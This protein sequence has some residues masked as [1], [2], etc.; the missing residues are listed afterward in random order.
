MVSRGLAEVTS[1]GLYRLK[2]IRD[3]GPILSQLSQPAAK[4][5]DRPIPA[6]MKER[7]LEGERMSRE[8]WNVTL[9]NGT[10]MNLEA[11]Y[12]DPFEMR[13]G[14]LAHGIPTVQVDRYQQE[15]S[16]TGRDT[17][18]DIHDPIAQASY[19]ALLSS[20]R[21]SGQGFQSKTGKRTLWPVSLFRKTPWV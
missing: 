1:P 12:Q 8:R 3:D 7:G 15:Y 21:E 2:L 18:L 10:C 4:T 20:L 19:S 5:P 13:D 6:G 14:R 17:Y 16:Q 11:K 9:N